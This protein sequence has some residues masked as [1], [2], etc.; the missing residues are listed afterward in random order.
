[1]DNRFMGSGGQGV[2]TINAG[3][4]EL[5]LVMTGGGTV[6]HLVRPSDE[7]RSGQSAVPDFYFDSLDDHYAPARRNYDH[8]KLLD[9]RWSQKTLCGREWVAMIGGVGGP[10]SGYEETAF[11]PSCRRCL[12]LMD[13]LFPAPPVDERLPLVSWLA[14]DQVAAHGYAEVHNVPGDQQA[15]LRRHVR[16]LVRKESGHGVQTMVHDSTVFVVCKA[17]YDQHAEEH[18]RA[19]AEAIN[20]LLAGDGTPQPT[21]RQEW[22]ISWDAWGI[23]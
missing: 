4:L 7:D 23:G 3:G 19:A 2:N 5:L 14:A 16:T 18:S 6:V 1:M 8:A 13:R 9:E 20:E 10:L 21:P 11:A 12:A 17:I 22:H 15:A